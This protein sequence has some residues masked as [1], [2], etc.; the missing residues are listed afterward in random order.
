MPASPFTTV[1]QL[2][3]ATAAWQD[4]WVAAGPQ[5]RHFLNLWWLTVTVS[6]AVFVAILAALVYALYQA[7]RATHITAP[8]LHRSEAGTRTRVVWAVSISSVLLVALILASVLTDRALGRLP[9]GAAI[10]IE[11]SAHQYWWEARYQS[12]EASRA[13]TTA[14]ELHIPVGRPVDVTLTADDVI[15]SFWVPNLQGKKD[16]IPG[17]TATIQLRADEAGTFRGQCA[18]FCGMQHAYMAFFVIAEPPDE[19]RAWTERQQSPAEPPANEEQKA[20]S[21]VF[22]SSTCAQCHTIAGTPATGRIGPD[23]THLASRKTIA[24]G[25][26]PNTKGHLA[27]WIV[28][29]QQIKPGVNMPPSE[30]AAPDLNAL[31]AFLE[32]LQ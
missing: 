8:V 16:L 14:N 18:E 1:A 26:L 31:L 19:Y 20:G 15:H 13:F 27:G 7:P 32:T 6:G 5:T 12:A 30:L 29:P 9:L 3:P 24:A 23:L 4:A 28:D 10:Q 22:M 2:T 25:M 17:H 11:V 21:T